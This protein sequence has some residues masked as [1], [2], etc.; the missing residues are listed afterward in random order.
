MLFPPDEGWGP[1]LLPTGHRGGSPLPPELAHFSL[2]TV[3]LRSLC[4]GHA[5]P[6][7][8]NAFSV[9]SLVPNLLILQD[10]VPISFHQ[11]LLPCLSLVHFT[12][13]LCGPPCQF[14]NLTHRG[15]YF[16]QCLSLISHP[17]AS[18]SSMTVEH[19]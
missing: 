8:R 19:S 17:R 1:G 16:I 10:I 13:L 3:L 11:Q 12:S 5:V 4:L 2:H 14:Q 6:S 18:Y 15:P 9:Q 7:A